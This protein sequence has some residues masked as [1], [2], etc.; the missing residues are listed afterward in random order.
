MLRREL[1]DTK[2]KLLDALSAPEPSAAASESPS[3]AMWVEAQLMHAR[4]QI[5]LLKAALVHRAELS[6][7]MEA[8]LLQHLLL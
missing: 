1:S 8:I 3:T 7:E 6:T 2:K 4:R 5:E